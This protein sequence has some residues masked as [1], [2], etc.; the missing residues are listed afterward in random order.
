M[1][2]GLFFDCSKVFP[3]YIPAMPTENITNPPMNSIKIEVLA[4]PGLKG[5]KNDK[6]NI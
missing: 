3:I 2:S 1:Y 4:Q 5:I 6:T